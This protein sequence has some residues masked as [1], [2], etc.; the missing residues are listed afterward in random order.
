MAERKKLAII[1]GKSV[2]YRGYYA[3]PN[4]STKDGTPT[5]GVYGFAVLALELIKRL[6]PDYVCVAWDKPKTNIRKRKQI[7]PEYK[8]NRKPPPP[9]FY[10]Q[11]PILHDLLDSF[12]WPLYELDDYE[13]DDIMGALAVQAREKDIDTMLI[14][15]DL[16]L[17]QVINGNVHVYA[18]KK[19]FSNIELYH[20][21][22]FE[23]KYGVRVD[24]FLDLKSLKG[25]SSDNIPGA[26][27]IGE[28]TAVKLLQ[29]FDNIDN[30]YKNLDD[31]KGSTRDKLIAGKDSVGISK[32]LARIWTD[33]PIKLN[34]KEV[35]GRHIKP[36]KV[37]DLLENLEFR[38]LTR[39]AKETLDLSGA[40]IERKVVDSYNGKIEIIKDD[41]GGWPKEIKGKKVFVHSMIRDS[42]GKDAA[43]LAFSVDSK[44]TY[45]VSEDSITNPNNFKNILSSI[46]KNASLIIGHDIKPL[47]KAMLNN[48]IE[49]S[50][51]FYDIQV[52]AFLYNSLESDI[53]IEGL[54]RRH[55]GWA[56]ANLA[57]IDEE[58]TKQLAGELI[59]NTKNI[60][61][62]L[63]KEISK[64]AE[65]ESLAKDVEMPMLYVLAKMEKVGI[66][67]DTGYLAKLG[68]ELSD[69]LS[70]IEQEIYG[71]ADEEF[72]I[73]SPRQLADI[74][75]EK[76]SLP[77]AGIKKGKTGYSTAA[78]ELAKLKFAHPIIDLL[79]SYREIS[80]LMNTYVKTLPSSVADDGRIHTTFSLTTAQTGRLSSH[81]PNLQNIP[82]KT[83]LGNK[84][85][86]AFKAN[87]GKVFVSADYS[88]F[89]LRLAAV[90][91]GDK[92]MIE[93]FNDGVDIHTITASQ[94]YGR[95][96]EDVTKTMRRD[97]KVIN[98]GILYGMSPHGLSEATGMTMV[99]A[100][101]FI[102]KYFKIRG[103][104]VKY[105]EK[106]KKQAIEQ[107]FVATYFGRRRYTPDVKS[108]NF[109]VRM[110]AERAAINMPIQGTASDIMKMAMIKIDK[111]LEEYDEAD[112]LLQ[113]HDSILI[114]VDEKIAED[115]A[116]RVRDIMEG[117]VKLPVN[118]TVDT[119]IAPNWADL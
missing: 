102:D 91:S 70:D 24:Q 114:E 106:L 21:E 29:D 95:N 44:N 1:D 61:E 35:D 4:L 30:I 58:M 34:L 10:E 117:V 15:S 90:L 68:D 85:R 57:D 118:I 3:M 48:D 72:N 116:H 41:A 32:Q 5:G 96:E 14:T 43:T 22:S 93:L 51:K 16:D 111:V 50:D 11:I 89:E 83:D 98:F 65:V 103:P 86:R 105:L 112:M 80:K 99:M 55:L 81:D 46:N 20:P 2:F 38:S 25:D 60:Y 52:A 73:N 8:A 108:S 67:V 33:A 12:G 79:Q 87:K 49:V 71:H 78:G 26:P 54:A 59:L 13:A 101:D 113:I 94:I 17:L 36:D 53:T 107:G 64:N 47:I 18:L 100:K 62:F 115:L 56:G 9:D 31:I 97:A 84:V 63:Q 75:F 82:T 74:L 19:G 39:Q 23:T 77:T 69:K 66:A 45:V 88:Q 119:A 40:V 37:L 109:V 110:A 28:K 104:L 27:G 42:L 92:E 7:Y 6:N 76:L